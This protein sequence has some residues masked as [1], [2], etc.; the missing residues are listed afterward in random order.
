MGWVMAL[1]PLALLALGFPVFLILLVTSTILLLFFMDVPLVQM[2]ITMFGSVDKFGLMAVPFFLFAGEL[3]G[4]GGISKRLVAWVLS[5]VGGVRGSLGLTTVGACTVFGA[6]SGSSPA[7]VAAIG[8]ILYRPLR[9]AGYDDRFA[10]GVLT[11]SGAIAIVIPPSIAMIIYG[12]AAEQNVALLFIAGI[13]PGLLIA[14]LMGL[15]IYLH[16]V[17]HGIRPTGGFNF[18]QVL[19]ATR[20]GGWALGMPAI[21]LGGIYAGIFSPTEA[22]GIACVYAIV[23]TRFIYRDITWRGLWQVSVNS[24]YLTAQVLIIVAAAGVFSWLLTVSGIPQSMVKAIDEL[25]LEPWMILLA[26]NILLLVVGCLLDPNSAILILVPLLLPIVQAIGV[27]LIH[28]GIIMTVNLSIG[29]FTPPF[30]LNIFVAQALFKVPLKS[31]YPGLVPF[32]A[33]NIV[34]LMVVTYIP[35]LSL[36][37]T[38]FVG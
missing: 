37:L 26:I 25:K 29:M 36:Y 33:I 9:G 20:D 2:H 19:R 28:F 14:A 21:I 24:M 13:L 10:S 34:A 16:A 4:R 38:R 23:V 32:I 6:I 27:D 15:Y 5:I 7:T 11:S 30:G 18:A 31:I 3:M 22:A 1:L 8:Q 12:T 35:S 17:R